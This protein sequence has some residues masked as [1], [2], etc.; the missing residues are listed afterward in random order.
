MKS[1]LAAFKFLGG[2]RL[3]RNDQT[4]PARFA[5]MA[6]YFPLVGL[7]LGC[8]LAI[9]NRA[10]EPYLESELL[11]VVLVATMI[12]VTRAVHLD[13]TLKTFERM[14][15]GS[16]FD[17]SARPTHVQGFLIVL[18][19]VLLKIRAVEVIGETRTLSLLLTPVL[20]R[21]S[22]LVFLYGA[23]SIA[24][25]SVAELARNVKAWHLLV[26]T[27]A[28]LAFAVY[29]VGRAGL[30][31]G[32]AVSLFALVSRSYLRRRGGAYTYDNLG[33][34]IELN[35]TLSLIALASL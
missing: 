29:L 26:T 8:V 14:S 4:R 18:L 13:G 10:V 21:W 32:L 27:T 12:L 34:I 6:V 19:V 25:E 3:S 16:A 35:E 2:E 11:A 9:V 28:T 22:L 1:A 33:A 15:H 30:W 23:H 31:I 20:A 5:G 24:E 17:E 7:I